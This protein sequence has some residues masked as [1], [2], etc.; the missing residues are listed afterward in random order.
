[1]SFD[2]AINIVF[3]WEGGYVYHPDDPGGET[4]HGITKRSFPKLDIKNLT[5]KEAKEI[6]HQY[7]WEPAKCDY[8]PTQL[9]IL[10]F[11]ASVQHGVDRAIKIL[12]KCLS[13][14]VDGDI[15][16]KTL[17]AIRGSNIKSISQEFT[18]RR[19]LFYTR[20]KPWHVFGLG[21]MRRVID[22]YTHSIETTT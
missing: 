17:T 13:V 15:G 9:S 18:V 20:L 14:K 4:N 5:K 22:V 21:W 19:I 1:M 7:F 8:I 11:S 2:S 16:P 12:Q 3:K 6:Y 10:V